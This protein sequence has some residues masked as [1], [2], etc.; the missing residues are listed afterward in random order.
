MQALAGLKSS[1]KL[2]EAGPMFTA[3]ITASAFLRTDINLVQWMADVA[4]C[5]YPPNGGGGRGESA[6]SIPVGVCWSIPI[7][8]LLCS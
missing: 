7:R 2:T 3:D 6:V 1:V 4:G 5:H 8:L